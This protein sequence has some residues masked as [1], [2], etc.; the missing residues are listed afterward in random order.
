M[1]LKLIF[2]VHEFY[3]DAFG[4]RFPWLL[5]YPA[6]LALSLEA[7]ESFHSVKVSFNTSQ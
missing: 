1:K 3:P 5:R 4:E 6:K 2:D 7:S